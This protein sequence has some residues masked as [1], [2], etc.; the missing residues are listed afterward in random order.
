MAGHAGRAFG[1]DSV[2]CDRVCRCVCYSGYLRCSCSRSAAHLRPAQTPSP[3]SSSASHPARSGSSVPN[4]LSVAH[5]KNL[6]LQC[7]ATS[8]LP[9]TAEAQGTADDPLLHS[10]T[11]QTQGQL[12][13]SSPPPSSPLIQ[14]YNPRTWRESPPS[15]PPNPRSRIDDGSSS[16][17]ARRSSLPKGDHRTRR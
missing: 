5:P 17:W 8:S 2:V 13:R 7:L 6:L 16:S 14:G 12:A 3:I 15:A 4:H 9:P 10:R 11:S 1:C